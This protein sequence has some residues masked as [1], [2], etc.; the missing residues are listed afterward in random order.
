M[1][2]SVAMD[3]NPGASEPVLD[4]KQIPHEDRER[5]LTLAGVASWIV[6]LLFLKRLQRYAFIIAIAAAT[7]MLVVLNLPF[8]PTAT[9]FGTVP[10]VGDIAAIMRSLPE[11]MMPQPALVMSRTA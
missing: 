11:L 10:T 8:M 5:R 2:G 6:A 9:Y 7:I 4:Q 3:M 1:S